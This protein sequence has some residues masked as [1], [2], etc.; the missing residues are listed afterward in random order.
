MEEERGGFEQEVRNVGLMA[1]EVQ[2]RSGELKTMHDQAEEARIEIQQLRG[3][4]DHERSAQGTELDQLRTMRTLIEQQRLQLLNTENELRGRGIEDVDVMIATQA[5]FPSEACT[6]PAAADGF[7][8]QMLNV[9]SG[10]QPHL[11]PPQ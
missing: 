7:P 4:L 11:L 3:Q 1:A 10:V 5:T 2:K 8:V 6:G 9:A